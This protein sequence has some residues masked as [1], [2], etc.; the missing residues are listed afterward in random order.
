MQ[1]KPSPAI[2]AFLESLNAAPRVKKIIVCGAGMNGD[3][4][5]ATSF[6]NTTTPF[7]G[8]SISEALELSRPCPHILFL[9]DP[10]GV[11]LTEDDLEILLIC[12]S[13]KNSALCYGDFYC[14]ERTPDSIRPVIPYQ[15]GSIRDDFFFG[16][17]M[18]VSRA[19]VE[20][21]LRLYGRLSGTTRA[22]LYELRLTLSLTGPIVK[23]DAPAGC[24]EKGWAREQSLFAYVDPGNRLYQSEMESV[25]TRHLRRLGAYCSH[26]PL[27]LPVDTSGPYP[28]TASVVIPVKNRAGTI[29]DA[30]TSALR[31]KTAFS[32]N[33]IVVQNHSSDGTDT[34]V[35]SLAERDSRVVHFIPSRK[36]HGIGGCWMEAV[37]SSCCGRY[38]CQ[39]DSDDLYDGADALQALVD[40]LRENQ[41]GMVAGS[42]RVVNDSLQEIPPGVIDHREWT[43]DNGRNNLLRVHGIGAPRA[44]PSY[45]LKLFPLPDVSY[46]EDYAAA[47]RLSRD[48]RVGRIYEPLYLCRRW[49]ENSDSGLSV[50][51]SNSHLYYKD[52]LRTQEIERR[53]A[54]NK[55]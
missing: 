12:A 3:P 53:C 38:V 36:N 51:Q 55:A 37:N 46:G 5:G 2:G 20:Q 33:V 7:S 8:D 14:S 21:A 26:E 52:T 30:V 35:Q 4:R 43:D 19:H 11:Q 17:F 39:L 34:I 13:Q 1:K 22:G 10:A 42:Y 24:V 29:E 48:Y 44:F 41:F 50:E 28:V 23:A 32:F 9:T 49:E 25:A 47:L 54:R 15:K 31:Q 27:A 16:P 40:K 45:M 18:F 6:V